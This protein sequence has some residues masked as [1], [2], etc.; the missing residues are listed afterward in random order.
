MIRLSQGKGVQSR[1]IGVIAVWLM[2]GS[3]PAVA[4]QCQGLWDEAV[5][6]HGQRLRLAYGAEL[7][8]ADPL[9]SE[10]LHQSRWWG[11]CEGQACSSTGQPSTSLTLPAFV[12]S[13]SDKDL[14]LQVS[15]P[16]PT[17]VREGIE[18]RAVDV[19]YGARLE[20]DRSVPLRIIDQLRIGAFGEVR[21]A[22][23]D[24]WIN[25]L[26]V[27]PYGR[28]EVV[29]EGRVRLFVNQPLEFG[30]GADLIADHPDT[31]VF[32]GYQGARFWGRNRIQATGYSHHDVRLGTYSE[33][34]G[35]LSGGDVQLDF[36]SRITGTPLSS[37]D[38]LLGLCNDFGPMRDLDGDSRPDGVDPDADGDGYFNFV[39]ERAESDPFEASSMPPPPEDPET[40]DLPD[41]WDPLDANACT[42]TFTNGL[43]T[44]ADDGSIRFG[45]NAQ[46]LNPS[47]FGLL[48]GRIDQPPFTHASHCENGACY[49][50]G[51]SSQPLPDFDVPAL[52]GNERLRVRPRSERALQSGD[53]QRYRFIRIQPR[54]SL[55]I[56]GGT[57]GFRAGNVW[58]QSRSEL[59]LSPGDYF[60]DS[61]NVDPG[62]VVRVDGEG[63]VRLHLDGE[64]SV[65]PY[66]RINTDEAGE[67]DAS[68]VLLDVAGTVD[69]S[70]QASLAA[71]VYSDK[72]VRSQG[73][74]DG[75]LSSARIS[76]RPYATVTY[77][78]DAVWQLDFGT[79]CDIDD[80]GVY[81]G[82][83]PDRDGD[84]ISNDYEK[85][86]GFDPND[87][88]S[89][90][91]DLDGDGIPDA[92]DDDRDGD[93]YLNQ[94]DR[95]PDDPTEWADMDNDGI[96]D[97]S[98]PDRDGD[99]F[100]NDDEIASGTNPNDA[101]DYP[102][103]IAPTVS[104]EQAPSLTRLA[105]VEVL[106]NAMD[107]YSGLKSVVL[108]NITT[109]ESASMQQNDDGFWATP[110]SLAGGMNNL[111]V[112]ATD[113]WDNQATVET[114]INRDSQAPVFSR[115]QP[116]SDQTSATSV[117]VVYR[118]T[119][120]N[121]G[122][123]SVE[124]TTPS[125]TLEPTVSGN[126]YQFDVPLTEGDN[127]LTVNAHDVAGNASST[128]L[129]LLSDVTAPRFD[130]V[131]IPELVNSAEQTIS[132]RISDN[133]TS[134]DLNLTLNGQDI[135]LTSD[136][137]AGVFTF[138]ADLM[139]SEGTNEL[140]LTATDAVG[141]S[142][143]LTR[144]L[145]LDTVAPVLTV[146]EPEPYWQAEPGYALTGQVTD[147]NSGVTTVVYQHGD[148]SGDVTWEADG[149]FSLPVTLLEGEQVVALTVTDLAGNET[150]LDVGIALD[151]T[152][153]VLS[154]DQTSDPLTGSSEWTLSGTVDD[155]GSGV[156]TLVLHWPGE[157][158]PRE[159]AVDN[160]GYQTTIALTEGVQTGRL[161]V[162]DGVGLTT[163]WPFTVTADFTAPTIQVSPPDGY[164]TNQVQ[165][166]AQVT[167]ADEPAGLH[168]QTFSLNGEIQNL[169]DAD[170]S[171]DLTLTEGL[172]EV[173]VSA[174]DTVS[175]QAQD[176]LTWN[177]DTQAPTLERLAP[178][179]EWTN[180]ATVLV[181]YGI[182]DENSGV[183]EASF[184]LVG[185]QHPAVQQDGAYQAELTLAEG[186]N[187]VQLTAT[188][189][190]GNISQDSLLIKA[191]YTPPR[192]TNVSV[193]LLVNQ[194]DLTVIGD[195][196]DALSGLS[197]VSLQLN[198]NAQTL[199]L[200]DTAEGAAFTA[201][202][203]LAEG[204]NTVE[205]VSTD[206]VGNEQRLSYQVN[207]DSQAPTIE[208]TEPA[209][210]WRNDSVIRIT[211]RIS[212]DNSG[213]DTLTYQWAGQEHSLKLDNTGAFSLDLTMTEG[214]NTLTVTA[215]DR[216]QNS[217]EATVQAG[218]DKTAPVIEPD[219]DSALATGDDTVT[220]S[221]NVS[222]LGSGIA[223]LVLQQNEA[224]ET[225]PVTVTEGQYSLTLPLTEGLYEGSLVVTD[226]VGLTAEWPFSVLMD[227][228]PPSL[229][230]TPAS[231]YL[232]NDSAVTA[233]WTLTDSGA[234]L[235]EQTQPQTL[236]LNGDLQPLPEGARA[237]ALTLAEGTNTVTLAAI[238]AV[239]NRSELSRDWVLDTQAPELT[240]LSSGEAT[241]DPDYAI[242]ARLTD[243]IGI[244][245]HQ[246]TANGQA[247]T[248][249]LDNDTVAGS[250]TL[251]DGN[252]VLVL[253]AT[254]AAGN[255]TRIEQTVFLDAQPPVLILDDVADITAANEI[256]IGGQ[257]TDASAVQ[258]TVADQSATVGEDGRFS[259]TVPVQEGGNDI[260][261]Q[262]IDALNNLTQDSLTITGDRTGPTVDW[263][264]PA[265]TDQDVLTVT[266]SVSDNYAEVAQLQLINDSLDGASFD[267]SVN[268]G[269]F[270][271]DV[272]LAP[273][274]NS[275]NWV[276]ED[277]VG[278]TSTTPFSIELQTTRLEWSW[279]SHQ[280]GQT[281]TEDSIVVEGLLDTDVAESDLSITVNGVE[282]RISEWDV[283]QFSVRSQSIDLVEG[284]N[285]ITVHIQA[286]DETLSET[287]VVYHQ[288]DVGPGP[289]EPLTLS[290]D[291]PANQALV[292]G[293]TVVVAGA[294]YSESIPQVSVNGQTAQL[295]GTL[296]DYRYSLSLPL[297]QSSGSLVVDVTAHN[298]NGEY[299]QETRS[300]RV[301]NQAPVLELDTP[302]A[303]YPDVNP[304]VANPYRLSGR[305]TDE[306]LASL[307]LNGQPVTL[308]PLGGDSHSFNVNLNLPTAEDLTLSLVA[309]DRAGNGIERNW[310]LRSDS[311]FDF[312][313]LLP[314]SESNLVSQGEAFDVQTVVQTSTIREDLNY[315]ARLLSVAEAGA[316]EIDVTALTVSGRTVSGMV[317]F[318]GNPG[319][320]RI[321]ILASNGDQTVAQT[322]RDVT[323]GE[324][325]EDAVAL[326]KTQPVADETG[327][328]TKEAISFFFNRSIDP[329]VLDIQ[330]FET[331]HGRTWANQD[332]PGADFIHARGHQLVDVDREY[333]PLSGELT[334]LAN[335]RTFIFV[336]EREPAYGAEIFV[337]VRYDDKT[338]TRYRYTTEPLP[339]LV[340][341]ELRDQFNRAVEGIRVNLTP[342]DETPSADT[343]VSTITREGAV[344]FGF[345]SRDATLS[346]GEYWLHI[347]PGMANGGYGE[348]RLP[349]S[350]SEGRLNELGL[351][352]ISRLNQTTG[353]V[354]L[355]SGKDHSL[356]D[357]AVRLDLRQGR[358]FFP[359]GATE[360]AAHL[361]FNLPGGLNYP[362]DP[363]AAPAWMYSFQPLGIALEGGVDLSL[364][365]PKRNDSYDY[366]PEEGTLALFLGVDPNQSRITPI[367]VARLTGTRAELVN[368]VTPPVLD[369]LGV[370]FLP[371]AYQDLLADYV[372]G[373]AGLAATL[374][375][376]T[377][378]AQT[379][380]GTSDNAPTNTNETEQ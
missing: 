10:S 319:D 169:P 155:V 325:G 62:A 216:A 63:T 365:L 229:T 195:V 79:Y 16:N 87:P 323:V 259:V 341:G 22:P 367:G 136:I 182:Q 50:L 233:E 203:A 60:F 378:R 254:D 103:R 109:G 168:E 122:V 281:V 251:Q 292:A 199:T 48:T 45:F 95:F 8:E 113:N 25:E 316:G 170:T 337:E 348:T 267:V 261:V 359:G 189:L 364:Q 380:A 298:G 363:V 207:L 239:G 88:T 219:Q 118:V 12:F 141:N 42:N 214:D 333:E 293:D 350:L 99:G 39:E 144:T 81:D 294:L 160:G 84:G 133:L 171:L 257:V 176:T 248:T 192:F 345:S 27:Q 230:L 266:G 306:A 173:I 123:E 165:I 2:L 243:N 46:L 252:N 114:Q 271:V 40:P 129:T 249:T 315:R 278:N 240:W 305:V 72:R 253:T 29:G 262:A 83:D 163:E 282:A 146:E 366:L 375:R 154:P 52:Y 346:G 358:I 128:T 193:P 373:D 198:G 209:P 138:T 338:L 9:P 312:S 166:A 255:T 121:S 272:A 47:S 215:L 310:L 244:A 11:A 362:V 179:T 152:A 55:V 132:G 172:N 177:L 376:I 108:T 96:G 225:T 44:H 299:I 224:T 190:A 313:W 234:G 158:E 181:R 308:T 94:D 111:S 119:D 369:H 147:D 110:V 318:P 236:S 332:E 125:L 352:P 98:D 220:L 137:D 357:G 206:A 187:S 97:N 355:A 201:N 58:L 59:R 379:A 18:F 77:N 285:T 196:S 344:L 107:E 102:D 178:L 38:Q 372:A 7:A 15:Q 270:S 371:D 211:G 311:A 335:E 288:D 167:L 24:Y 57:E 127:L 56:E 149:T 31:V 226:N 51:Q 260:T 104:I 5:Q 183:Q 245:T 368:G 361:Q 291:R 1:L 19:P 75:A 142:R 184:E 135:P 228:T 80:D 36:G 74:I 175:N 28:I 105:Q 237:Q 194:A 174:S 156:T 73:H 327:V 53:S 283:E 100:D 157:T 3:L 265:L 284:E 20:F 222:D 336:P 276:A 210:Y 274:A 208:L 309:I 232:T 49:A 247:V 34:L 235:A 280:P 223:D 300:I 268:E 349:V 317:R 124:L 289:G 151:T 295:T 71:L 69:I 4:G 106:A 296:P 217:A 139:L 14:S 35:R 13:E 67:G 320:F 326:L 256:A 286:P 21:L 250:I 324:A 101:T 76:L 191:D 33:L 314:L 304:S 117:T 91:P 301:D 32:I 353:G 82:R 116:G 264:A 120:D 330:V 212:D 328:S 331:A 37:E 43:Q 360:G 86:L 54:A 287:L 205:L 115:L 159:L 30:Y 185:E 164:L 302:L 26:T 112:T 65:L 273:G 200:T 70:Y 197:D 334:G 150:S 269:A 85:E 93:G 218:L 140:V 279:L 23:G 130:E 307:T 188:D 277:S 238:D 213:L 145:N 186:D 66:G 242:G 374:A 354:W 161:L 6:S 347:N 241:N 61:L 356:L 227:V 329:N 126:D 340:T 134:V 321:Q 202:L 78:P 246:L 92:L 322:E 64:L 90:P 303:D 370:V 180:A 377:S 143:T 339:T 342:V 290:V 41:A 131:Q 258:V 204:A 89:T 162:T 343:G 68:Q 263:S 17:V 148:Q 275:L 231:G 221:G 351:L 153:P 297:N